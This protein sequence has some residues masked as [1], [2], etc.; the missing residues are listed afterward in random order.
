MH[1][2]ICPRLPPDAPRIS[3]TPTHPLRLGRGYRGLSQL[4]RDARGKGDSPPSWG[5][6]PP[7]WGGS[8]ASSVS[9]MRGGAP[10]TSFVMRCAEVRGVRLRRMEDFREFTYFPSFCSFGTRFAY[11]R[12]VPNRSV[13]KFLDSCLKVRHLATPK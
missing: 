4:L 7:S 12:I 11:A 1:P 6:A 2:E 9:E 8:C 13:D 5:A 3:P 10:R